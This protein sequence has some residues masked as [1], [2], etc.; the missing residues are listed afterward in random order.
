MLFK[1]QV[2]FLNQKQM[3][4]AE[5]KT[6]IKA[7]KHEDKY[8]FKPL[9]YSG[10]RGGTTISFEPNTGEFKEHYLNESLYDRGREEFT[11]SYTETEL[12]QM[13]V[14][15]TYTDQKYVLPTQS[16]DYELLPRQ[17]SS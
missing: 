10:V 1:P 5:A 14:N 12:L 6:I 17:T 3:K 2:Y 11:K 4:T 13:F 8:Y 7:L 9:P 16:E 15:E